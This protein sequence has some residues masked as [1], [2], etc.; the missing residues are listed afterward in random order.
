MKSFD[1][2]ENR[3][4]YDGWISHSLNV[5]NIRPIDMKYLQKLANLEYETCL[6]LVLG[7]AIEWSLDIFVNLNLN[8]LTGPVFI[9]SF[10][11]MEIQRTSHPQL[12][13]YQRIPE[14]I[15]QFLG[16]IP[17]DQRL[18]FLFEL[19]VTSLAIEPL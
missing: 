3:Y 7:F 9:P 11:K 15:P 18:S 17:L 2:S 6:C 16:N 13:F 19:L 1:F 8:F 10:K 14:F 5:A 4:Q 12:I